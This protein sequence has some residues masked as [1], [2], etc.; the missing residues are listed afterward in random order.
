[1]DIQQL[2]YFVCVAEHLNFTRAAKELFISQPALSKQIFNL[3]KYFGVPLFLRDKRFMR[4]TEVGE[5]LLHEAQEIL[6]KIDESKNKV[7]EVVSG[8]TGKLKIGYIGSVEEK[9]L[10]PIAKNFSQNY[11]GLKISIS[12]KC[13]SFMK[14]SLIRGDI[15]IGFLFVDAIEGNCEL[16]W[17][18]IFSGRVKAVL[19]SGHLLAKKRK[20]SIS[21]LADESFV[22]PCR[23][24]FSNAY[25][26]SLK[27]C[28][29]SGFKPKII[30]YEA[31]PEELLLMVESGL[32]ITLLSDFSETLTNK[33]VNFVNLEE[34]YQIQLA[35]AWKKMNPNPAVP[36]FLEKFKEMLSHQEYKNYQIC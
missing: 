13:S 9:I 15:D 25:N 12:R 22:F 8:C 24:A 34:E 21:V 35:I 3:E 28:T 4:L 18:T 20:I 23:E 11:P 19:P 6:A 29:A 36:L 31:T 1:M 10:P 5:V 2:R 27:M 30:G 17:D 7:F 33:K 26:L 32:G 14:S 16:G